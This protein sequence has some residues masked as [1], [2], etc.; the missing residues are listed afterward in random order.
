MCKKLVSMLLAFSTVLCLASCAAQPT[1]APT[2]KKILFIGNSA[3][4]VNDIPGTLSRLAQETGYTIE[5]DSI[6]QG[7]ASLITFSDP[8]TEL[9]SSVRNALKN[10]Y[11]LVFLQDNGNCIQSADARVASGLACE[12]LAGEITDSG[13]K[14]GLYFRP[15]YGYEKWG[16]GPFEQCEQFDEHF[17]AISDT[18]H[19]CVNVFVNRAFAIA[20]EETVFNLW[21]EDNAHTSPY[22]A[23]LAVC[24]FFATL[25]NTSSTVLGANGLPAGDARI[26]QNIADRVALEG[27]FPF[28][29][30]RSEP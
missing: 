28:S 4:Y 7:G 27:Q 17:L 20:D 6:T 18:I 1:A 21:G 19:S 2:P 12:I 25:F 13:A 30:H 9:G 10:G 22:G 8:S 14:V 26:L 15:P 5:C 3:T 23:Y 24:V 11:D 16:Y 29:T